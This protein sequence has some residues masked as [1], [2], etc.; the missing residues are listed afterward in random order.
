MKNRIPF[1]TIIV[2]FVLLAAPDIHAQYALTD[3]PEWENPMVIG[4]NKEPARSIF[5][6]YADVESALDNQSHEFNSP[7]HKSLNGTWKF[8][9]SENPFELPQDFFRENYDVSDW[10]DIEVPGTWQMQGH[11]MPIYRNSVYPQRAFMDKIHPPLVPKE[12]N[13]VGSYR[14]TFTV[15]KNWDGRQTFIHFGGVK[16]GFYLW[17]NGE[18]VGYS[19]GSMTPA[20]FNITPFLKEGENT[21]AA[22]VIR[23]TDGSWLE[24]QDMW[25]F[26][27]IYRDVFMYSMPEVYIQDFFVNAPLDRDYKHGELEVEVEVRNN[28]NDHIDRQQVEVL[29]FDEDGNQVEQLTGI[30][31]EGLPAGTYNRAVVS[32][33]IE[34]VNKWTAETPYLYTV[35]VILKDDEGDI[36]QVAKT[37]TGFRTIEIIDKMFLVNGREVKLKGANLH[38]HDPFKGRTVDLKWMKEDV[39]LMKQ[40]NFNTMRM[41]HY[42][43]HRYY[44]ELADEYGLYVIDE[45][46]IET[47]GISFRNQI[48][49]GGDPYW[50]NAIIDR[51]RSMVEA[52]KN[53]PSIV[54]WSLGNEAGY[55]ENFEQMAS[56][57]RTLDPSR[58]IHYQHMNEVADMASYMYPS[59]GAVTRILN[60]PNIDQPVI[61]CEFVHSMGNSTG[62][63]DEYTKL[64]KENR[65]FIGMYVWDWVDQGLYKEDENGRMFWAYGGDFGHP[66]NDGNFNFNGLV[67]PD[68]K[69]NPA[70][71]K[72]KYSYQFVDISMGSLANKDVRIQNEYA[73]Y[74]LNNFILNWSL[75]EDGI[76]IQ[77]GEVTALDIPAGAS[78]WIN[79]PFRDPELDAGR[80]YHLNISLH[81]K[82]AQKWA[83]AGF[84]MAWEQFKLPYSVAK[85]EAIATDDHSKVTMNET[86]DK[87]T[88]S[89]DAFVAEVS[90]SDGLITSYAASDKELL[91]SK[92]Q[93]N[94]WRATTDND[95]AGWRESLDAWKDAGQNLTAEEVTVNENQIVVKAGVP[96]GDTKMNISYTFLGNGAVHVNYELIPVGTEIPGFI[97]KVGMQVQIPE[98]FK[99]MTWFGRGPEE[100]YS[101]RK[102]GINVGQYS[103]LID[104]LWTDYGYPQENANRTEIRWVA[105]TNSEG[106]GFIAVADEFINVSAWPY[107]LDELEKATHINELPRRDFYTVNLDLAQQGVG[108]TDSW[109]DNARALPEYRLP[110]DK[111]YTYGFY[112]MPYNKSDGDLTDIANKAFPEY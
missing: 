105:F 62:N 27:G 6:P 92:L 78:K 101:D 107:T 63:L 28:S 72:V 91:G 77:S 57:I 49:P 103:G 40:S 86:E 36:R 54:I 23:W 109:S 29:L 18:K 112:I 69:P 2:G 13:P 67:S 41:S 75:L 45:A 73:D 16:S 83:D 14:T 34:G 71:E 95:R 81:L 32:A 58:P 3:L 64:M 88:I 17:I 59:V 4:V 20:E 89:S 68:R 26:A 19:E 30:T 22:Q 50:Q 56:Y 12:Y 39:K 51:G 93:P 60:D 44:Y 65:N 47:H 38:E 98:A 99:T 108:G 48:L 52:N 104:D 55:G 87:I 10:E 70:L 111:G 8:M 97:P 90:K 80:E 37:K 15:P 74:N 84:K 1:L 94:F 21:L 35:V 11:G 76:V 110:T 102:I 33:T 53:H 43:H 46:N 82:E 61:L 5:I 66:Y 79:I 24:D 106:N 7:Y 100:N 85:A 25:R 9:W 31:S 42:P 96:V